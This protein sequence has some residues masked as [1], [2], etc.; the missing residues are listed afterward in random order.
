MAWKDRVKSYQERV[1]VTHTIDE[2]GELKFYPNR[3]AQLERLKGVSAT[4][5]ESIASLFSDQ[6][7]DAAAVTE[8]GTDTEGFTVSKTTVSA[9]SVEVMAY[10]AKEQSGAISKLLDIVDRRNLM[11][12]GEMFMDCLRDEFVYA[13]QR[14]PQDVEE[15]LYGAPKADE[16][17][18]TMQGDGS[19]DLTLFVGLFQGWMKANAKVFGD[20]GEKLVGLVRARLQ[21]ASSE[22]LETP[23]P[24]SGEGS[25]TVSS[26]PAPTDGV[27]ID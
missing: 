1:S 5:I 9:V 21:T 8:S 15:F 18:D 26:P 6:R 24:T 12:L 14:A 27:L 7:A 10:R 23:I 11:L 25:K 22:N 17:A 20:V 16:E 3:I 4:V 13:K 19:L 2:L